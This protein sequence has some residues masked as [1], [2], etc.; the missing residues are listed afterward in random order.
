M[1]SDQQ[2]RY[3][4]PTPIQSTHPQQKLTNQ[5]N[6]PTPHEQPTNDNSKQNN[7]TWNQTVGSSKE[8]LGN[9]IGHENLRKSGEEQNE[10]G[11]EQKAEEQARTWGEAIGDRAKG[12]VGSVEA[13]VKGDVEKE[14]KYAELRKGGKEKEGEVEREIQG[15]R[16]D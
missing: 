13:V 8:A 4:T 14:K 16:H 1:P 3:T 6:H 7:P 12:T 10:A 5:Q 15:S 9:L 2:V 11:K